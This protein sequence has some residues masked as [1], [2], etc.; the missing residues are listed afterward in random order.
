M[1]E[2]D[3]RLAERPREAVE[4]AA[5]Y[6]VAEALTNV[7]RYAGAPQARVT[8]ERRDGQL[9]V[10]V[11]DDGCGG[12]DPA[13]GSGL[14]GLADR[15][16][17]LGGRLDG[18]QPGRRGHGRARRAAVGLTTRRPG[19]NSGAGQREIHI[20]GE[21]REEVRGSPPVRERGDSPGEAER[22]TGLRQDR[23]LAHDRGE[24]GVRGG[25]PA[26]ASQVGRDDG[27]RAVPQ[28]P[29]RPRRRRCDLDGV[30]VV[31]VEQ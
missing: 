29:R 12:A 25:G 1:V 2:L 6:V 15:V 24:C 20:D 3:M 11:A 18:A 5:Y 14:R 22:L 10:E 9:S 8:V 21:P 26:E 17:A 27:H 16:E 30:R 13:S 7:V 28:R 23:Q 19:V 31:E 4:A